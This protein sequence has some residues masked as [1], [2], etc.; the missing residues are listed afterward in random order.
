MA[1]QWQE[2]IHHKD[3]LSL[4]TCIMVVMKICSYAACILPC[5]VPSAQT[6]S[7]PNMQEPASTLCRI[8]WK[9]A[10]KSKDMLI[11]FKMCCALNTTQLSCEK[12]F[13]WTEWP[14]KVARFCSLCQIQGQQFRSR[15]VKI[16]SVFCSAGNVR[17]MKIMSNF[18]DG[19]LGM[20]HHGK[21]K[22]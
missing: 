6:E 17:I 4:P 18:H 7:C 19:S 3:Y 8:T 22:I 12:S 11:K 16:R 13:L 5:C 15:H 1:L 10:W 2:G 9:S 21:W 14:Y 20:F